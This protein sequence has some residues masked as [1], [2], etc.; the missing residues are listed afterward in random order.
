MVRFF[1]SVRLPLVE[2]SGALRVT[3]AP[4]RVS[5][6][7]S[8]SVVSARLPPDETTNG[9]NDGAEGSV[10]VVA[11]AVPED[12]MT[13]TPEGMVIAVVTPDDRSTALPSPHVT[14]N[15][16]GLVVP[17]IADAAISQLAASVMVYCVVL[18]DVAIA[19]LPDVSFVNAYSFKAYRW[20]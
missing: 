6:F 14:V 8:L 12:A 19:H 11:A 15:T 2:M 9:V 20:E 5:A 1:P 17:S 7:V 18:I 13:V 10:T 3:S 4:V 16:V